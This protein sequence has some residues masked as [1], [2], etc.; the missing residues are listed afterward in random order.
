MNVFILASQLRFNLPILTTCLGTEVNE[1]DLD[2]ATQGPTGLRSIAF[3]TMQG[4]NTIRGRMVHEET[5]A[6]LALPVD[7]ERRQYGFLSSGTVVGSVS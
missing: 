3:W 1:G 4:R 2:K 5:D 7:P 6:S